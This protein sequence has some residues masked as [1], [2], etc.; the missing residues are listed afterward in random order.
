MT[1]ITSLATQ[2]GKEGERGACA[3]IRTHTVANVAMVR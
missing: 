2:A 1:K 3:G